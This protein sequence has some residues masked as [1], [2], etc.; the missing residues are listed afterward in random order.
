MIGK[1]L[2]NH[3]SVFVAFAFLQSA[4]WTA[5]VSA[6]PVKAS[7]VTAQSVIELDFGLLEQTAKYVTDDKSDLKQIPESIRALEGKTVRIT[8]YLLLPPEAY[9]YDDPVVHFAVSK[10]PFGCPCC[11]WGPPPTI[12]NTVV[13][14]MEKGETVKPPFTP[15]VEVTGTFNIRKEQYIDEDGRK[16]LDMIFYVKAIRAEKKKQSFLGSIF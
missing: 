8:G 7:P 4:I 6:A 10:D 11:T 5:P 2:K 16:C 13:V 15:L 3:I 12:F 14:D 9:Y 1:S